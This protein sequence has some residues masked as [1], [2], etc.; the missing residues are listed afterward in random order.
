M[1]AKNNNNAMFICLK[2]ASEL[3]GLDTRTL[4]KILENTED[5]HYTRIGRKII[6]DKAELIDYIKT[7]R[8][9]NY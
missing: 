1:K 7:H 2:Q 3:I 9:I 5:L 4:K 6:I 8:K